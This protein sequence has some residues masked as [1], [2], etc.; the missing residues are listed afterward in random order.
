MKKMKCCFVIAACLSSVFLNVSDALA[1]YSQAVRDLWPRE[2]YRDQTNQAN[3]YR[4]FNYW[5]GTVFDTLTRLTWEQTPS[6]ETFTWKEDKTLG[7]AQAYCAALSKA[8]LDWRVPNVMELQSLIDYSKKDSHRIHPIFSPDPEGQVYWTSVSFN[9]SSEVLGLRMDEGVLESLP[10]DSDRRVRCVSGFV[11]AM[12][13][14]YTNNPPGDIVAGNISRKIASERRIVL[15]TICFCDGITGLCWAP[16]SFPCLSHS[17]AV[18]SCDRRT[19][20]ENSSP[21]ELADAVKL[22]GIT[23][24]R[25]PSIKEVVT[26]VD[27]K[28]G[29]FRIHEAA[30]PLLEPKELYYWTSTPHEMDSDSFAVISLKDGSLSYVR[31]D[32]EDSSKCI[33]ARC[34]D[35]NIDRK[36]ED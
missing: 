32:F 18:A 4:T 24:W 30:Q 3:R 8:G 1:G 2:A 27:Y 12:S 29:K 21:K 31:S 17:E 19:L 10:I 34:V 16:K 7:S 28:S 35:H 14:E 11:N 25:L 26:L 23:S 6:E 22:I 9:G 20:L 36:I 13:L 33:L 5:P 15:V